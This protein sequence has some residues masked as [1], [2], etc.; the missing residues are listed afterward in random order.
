MA[1][2]IRGVLRISDEAQRYLCNIERI[3]IIGRLDLAYGLS[4]EYS[5]FI[6]Y[7]IAVL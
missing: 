5:Q 4:S 2:I 3:A 7:R 6:A 1:C